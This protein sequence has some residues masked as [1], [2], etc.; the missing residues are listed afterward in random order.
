MLISTAERNIS[1]LDYIRL[2]N[3][4]RDDLGRSE[5]PPQSLHRLY[6]LLNSAQRCRP[7]EIQEDTVT[8]N[9]DI[10][11]RSTRTGLKSIIRIIYP[12]EKPLFE[13]LQDKVRYLTIYDPIALGLLGHKVD[14][15]CCDFQDSL[16]PV[17]IEKVLFQP[18]T[19]KL[20]NL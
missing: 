8:M 6:L 7:E 18:E 16:E 14:D 13:N 3:L 15:M 20:F 10:M 11:V 17:V 4:L 2:M 5:V 1:E 12:A 9:S 19:Y